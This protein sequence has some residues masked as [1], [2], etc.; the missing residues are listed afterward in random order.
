MT[1]ND[2]LVKTLRG[3]EALRTRSA[4]L[5]QR[6]RTVLILV[7]GSRSAGA[8]RAAAGGVGAAPDC[9]KTLLEQGLVQL[10][11]Q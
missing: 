5:P 3:V 11:S 7:D 8:L 4:G 2:I 6:L 10:L 1:N 9:L